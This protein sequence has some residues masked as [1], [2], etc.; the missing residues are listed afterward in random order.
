MQTANSFWAAN[1]DIRK[2]P[3]MMACVHGAGPAVLEQAS[4]FVLEFGKPR[5]AS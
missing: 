5:R 1:G 4:Q 3:E 2:W